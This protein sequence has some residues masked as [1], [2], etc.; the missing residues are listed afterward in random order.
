MT[1]FDTKFLIS[2]KVPFGS[3]MAHKRSMGSHAF[4]ALKKEYQHNT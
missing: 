3:P 2:L 4:L 1:A